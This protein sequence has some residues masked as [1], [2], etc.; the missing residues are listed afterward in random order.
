MP[1]NLANE[2]EKHGKSLIFTRLI[3]RYRRD[4]WAV[5]RE[6]AD[7][8]AHASVFGAL[9]HRAGN[10]ARGTRSRQGL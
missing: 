1:H 9:E 5:D 3:E 10:T 7:L 8:M 6:M 2:M 4:G